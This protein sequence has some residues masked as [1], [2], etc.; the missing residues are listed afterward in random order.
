M[1]HRTR[2]ELSLWNNEKVRK[3]YSKKLASDIATIEPEENLEEHAKKIETAIKKAVE[4]TI[5]SSRSANKPWISEDTLK[6]ADEKR[7]L[8]Q[9]K[10]TSP[11]KKQQYKD[12]CKK[13][14]KSARQDKERWIQ[15]QCEEIEKG[16][17]IGRMRQA[18]IL[19][20]I[21]RRK[22]TPRISVIKDQH[23][24][25]L[26]SQDEI[27]RQWTKYCSSLYKD[28]GESDSMTKGLE[29]IS[30]TSTEEPRNILYSEVE[31]AIRT[32]KRNKSPRSDRIIAEMIQAG[33]GQLVPQIH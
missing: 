2:I 26:Q 22:F 3:C 16:L 33:G 7:T 23:G 28:Q 5:S 11:Q 15:Q 8:K 17:A 14:K 19:T 30:P 10:N 20:K 29:M 12:L 21:L 31:E 18:Y 4:A 24:K 13:V 32:L 27:I 9:T 1:Q 6:S 25:V